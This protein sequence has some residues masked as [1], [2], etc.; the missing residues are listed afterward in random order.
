MELKA[1]GDKTEMYTNISEDDVQQANPEIGIPLEIETMAARSGNVV[2]PETGE[3][4]LL[5]S[6]KEEDNPGA[7]ARGNK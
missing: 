5:E 7:T 3:W 6:G 1:L 2:N 4:E